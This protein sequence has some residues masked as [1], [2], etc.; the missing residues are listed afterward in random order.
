MQSLRT[1]RVA[2]L[3]VPLEYNCSHLIVSSKRLNIQASATERGLSEAFSNALKCLRDVYRVEANNATKAATEGWDR[4]EGVWSWNVF[5]T[6]S[7]TTV[8]VCSFPLNVD[9]YPYDRLDSE[10][11][12]TDAA[13]L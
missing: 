1:G 13:C 12:N 6:S 3:C 11:I 7:R 2:C 9:A 10:G 5:W 8:F 4:L